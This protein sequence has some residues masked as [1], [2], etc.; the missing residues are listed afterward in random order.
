MGRMITNFPLESM[1]CVNIRTAFSFW[2]LSE[3][4]GY[5]QGEGRGERLY[6]NPEIE[7]KQTENSC[8]KEKM[9]KVKFHPKM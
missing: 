9:E 4:E 2:P 7:E 8:L 6:E 3:R 1:G 5:C